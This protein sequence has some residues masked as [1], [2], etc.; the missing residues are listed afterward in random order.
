MH[1]TLA[2]QAGSA[3]FFVQQYAKHDGHCSITP[4]EVARGFHELRDWKLK[5]VRPDGGQVK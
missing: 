3:A 1:E 2:D 5:R 4:A